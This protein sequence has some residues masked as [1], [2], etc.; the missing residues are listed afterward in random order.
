[1][2]EV[3]LVHFFRINFQFNVD[4]K[5]MDI[6][7]RITKCTLHIVLKITEIQVSALVEESEIIIATC[8]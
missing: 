6:D 5:K 2:R 3:I 1:M 7:I 8:A 4:L